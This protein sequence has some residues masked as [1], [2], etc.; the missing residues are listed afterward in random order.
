MVDES[1]VSRS[2]TPAGSAELALIVRWRHR[3]GRAARCLA[4]VHVPALPD[5]PLA[6]LTEYAENPTG[7]GIANDPGGAADALLAVL[8]AG[9]VE[10]GDLRWV[11]HHGGFSYVDSPGAPE[12]F[13][14][15]TLRWDG[16]H[17]QSDLTDQ[18][19]LTPAEWDLM[20]GDM[21]LAPVGE[22]LAELGER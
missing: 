16:R 6:L 9:L 14:A 3:S 11:L 8:P 12:T 15:V 10:P 2:G 13:T 22:V 7:V 20:R 5:R 18:R 19:L 21:P 17:H 1:A 4:R